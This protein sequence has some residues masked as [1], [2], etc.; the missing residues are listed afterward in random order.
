M[1]TRNLRSAGQKLASY[2]FKNDNAALKH[3]FHY[4]IIIASFILGV[5]IATIL[6]NIF[7]QAALLFCCLILIITLLILVY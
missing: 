4:L 5:I 1:Y 3:C 2:L 6:I 7:N